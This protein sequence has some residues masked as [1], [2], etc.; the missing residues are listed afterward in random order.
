M[1]T[2]SSNLSLLYHKLNNGTFVERHLPEIRVLLREREFLVKKDC[3]IFRLV[4]V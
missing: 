2:S 3:I 1:K 4:P